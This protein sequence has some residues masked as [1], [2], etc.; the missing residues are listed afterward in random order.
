ML[1][2]RVHRGESSVVDLSLDSARVDRRSD[3]VATG[4]DDADRMTAQGRVPDAD[5]TRELTW[6]RQENDQLRRTLDESLQPQPIR[7]PG[8]VP[9]VL[10]A[11]EGAASDGLL[12]INTPVINSHNG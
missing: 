5:L 12:V 7:E 2:V 9:A 3:A 6:A 8:E 10:G 11:L 4:D 1:Y